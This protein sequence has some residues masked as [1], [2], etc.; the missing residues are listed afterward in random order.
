[1]LIAGADTGHTV[2][3]GD[4]RQLPPI[5]QATEPTSR[6]WLGKSAFEKSGVA[7]AV[8]SGHPPANL[9]ALDQQHRMRQQIG[10]AIGQSF[11][12]EARIEVAATVHTRPDRTVPIHQPHTVL[13][14]TSGLQAPIARR[15][16]FKS[17]YNVMHAQLAANAI[18]DHRRAATMPSS[19][20]LISPFAPQAK[21]LQAFAPHDDSRILASTVHRFQG[22]ETDVVLYDTVESCGTAL[23]PH[24]WF[25][26]THMGSEG[27]RLMNVAMSRA[28]EQAI[29]LADMGYVRQHCPS[30][31]PVREFLRH[32]SEHAQHRQWREVADRNGPTRVEP[33][34]SRLLHDLAASTTRW[35]YSL[36]LPTGLSH[37]VS[38]TSSP[39]FRTT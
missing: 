20:G 4:F 21:L 39:L 32:M 26:E 36:R 5:V 3:A 18:H 34:L 37:D 23:N 35:T 24:R 38:S 31:T 17:R 29:M 6:E 33:D 14:D 8:K 11:Y 19:I 27:A 22:G 1:M 12:P 25:T 30:R 2:I 28:R 16:G 13:I 9:V 7:N 10:D 15:G